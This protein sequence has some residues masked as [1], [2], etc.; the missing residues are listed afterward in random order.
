[1]EITGASEQN[2]VLV[3]QYRETR[4]AGD[5]IT[6]QV[7]TSPFAIVALPKFAGDVRFERAR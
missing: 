7:I 4:P 6:A 1:V 3:V 5:A 2:G